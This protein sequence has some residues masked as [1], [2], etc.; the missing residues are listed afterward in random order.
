M[1]IKKVDMYIK[2]EIKVLSSSTPHNAQKQ[3][4]E[5]LNGLINDE[6]DIFCKI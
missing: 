3:I 5:N 1:K 2:I 6:L 4:N